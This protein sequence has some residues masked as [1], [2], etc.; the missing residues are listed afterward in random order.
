[1]DKEG[2]YGVGVRGAGQVAAQHAAAILANPKLRLA[3]ISSRSRSSAEK[4]AAEWSA[5]AKGAPIGIFDSYESMIESPDVDIV[6]ECMPNYL[7]A[8]EAILAFQAGK[9]LILEKPAAINEREL[10]DLREAAQKSGKKSVVSFVLRWHPMIANI[11][12]L[13]THGAIGDVFCSSFDYWHGIKP[14][15]SSYEWI[16]KKEFAGGAMITGGCHAADIARF[17]HG[18]IAEVSA[19]STRARQDFD[20]PTTVVAAVKYADGTVGRLS[21]CLDGLAYPYQ[22]NI[23]LLGTRGAIRDNRFYSKEILPTQ[24]DF[25][26]MPCD[27]PNS[28]SV[29]HHPFKQ[30]IDNLV[31]ALEKGVPVLSDVLDACK[32]MEVCLAVTESAETGKPMK[33][34]IA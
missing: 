34:G 22:F 28:G 4:L 3:A 7:H 17:L 18:E 6:S 8:K 5:A 9:H 32:T 14:T 16:R 24:K 11:R 31:D 19:F 27:T 15:F 26:I 33:V 29:E 13:Q 21:V 10:S 12:S 25:A 1:M 30:E 2:R 23:D 20:Y